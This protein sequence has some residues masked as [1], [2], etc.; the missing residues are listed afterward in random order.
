MGVCGRAGVPKLAPLLSRPAAGQLSAQML[1]YN[2]GALAVAL[3]LAVAAP[4]A[5]PLTGVCSRR[6]WKAAPCACARRGKYE[7]I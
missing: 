6:R 7:Y 5:A 2:P 4:S 3:A 1:Q